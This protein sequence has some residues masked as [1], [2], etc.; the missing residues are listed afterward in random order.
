MTHKRSL[1]SYLTP[2][3][4]MLKSKEIRKATREK[5]GVAQQT[6]FYTELMH[7]SVRYGS[8]TCGEC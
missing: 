1:I 3:L 2:F 8:K 5:Y 4:C 6:G 7:Y